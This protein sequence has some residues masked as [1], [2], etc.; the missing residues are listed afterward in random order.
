[1]AVVTK[2]T[3]QIRAPHGNDPRAVERKLYLQDARG[4]SGELAGGRN[5]KD[6]Q[7][8]LDGLFRGW[9]PIARLLDNG[10]TSRVVLVL[11]LGAMGSLPLV[12][13]TPP[14]QVPDEVQHFYRAYQLSEFHL[15]AEVQNGAAGGT[16]PSS[17][18]QMVKASVYTSDGIA[19]PPTPAPITKTL[20]LKSIPLDPSTKQ[21]VAFPGSAFYSPLPYLPQALGIAVGRA[22][23]AGPLLL[24]YLGRLGNCLS[25]L[26][27]LCLTVYFAPFAEEVFILAGLLPMSLYLYASLSPDAAVIGCALAFTALSIAAGVQAS[28]GTRELWLAAAL[29]A[30][31]CSVKPPYAPIILAGV[32]P[33]LFRPG[34]ALRVIRSTAILLGVALGAT[35]GW[36]LYAKST[37]TTPLSGTHPSQQIVLVLHHPIFLVRELLHILGIGSLVNLY[38][39]GVGVFGWLTVLLRPAI[40]YVLPLVSVFLLWRLGVRGSQERSVISA[41]WYLALAFTSAALIVFTLYLWWAHVGQDYAAGVQG[42]YFIPLLGLAGIGAIELAPR[43]RTSAAQWQT[44]L[45]IAVISVIEIVAMDTTIIRVFHVL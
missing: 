35:A 1:M 8:R 6:M 15:R 13:L 16:L 14:F 9:Q 30:V 12:I 44:L 31:F 2:L 36:L 24:L 26:A 21:F 40:V 29:A 38:V 20:Q 22:M 32:M 25:A 4:Q 11:I 41:L 19:Y 34:S 17:L 45:S 10:K 33:G 43:R 7:H 42:R 18:P 37:M 27:L 39:Q 5:M 28:R 23:G 3:P